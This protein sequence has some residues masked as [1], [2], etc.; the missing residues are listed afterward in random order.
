MCKRQ[1]A[2]YGL[3]VSDGRSIALVGVGEKNRPVRRQTSPFRKGLRR[4]RI[5]LHGTVKN[6]LM[7]MRS[8]FNI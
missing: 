1:Q 7:K 6:K 5:M 2:Y 4:T 8:I 3:V